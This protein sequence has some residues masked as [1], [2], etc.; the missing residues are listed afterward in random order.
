MRDNKFGDW[1][2]FFIW[3]LVAIVFTTALFPEYAMAQK[4]PC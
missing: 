4:A 2:W 3:C 1:I